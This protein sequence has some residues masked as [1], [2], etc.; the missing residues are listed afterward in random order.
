MLDDDDDDDD[1]I[2]IIFRIT[3]SMLQAFIDNKH[4]I[5]R[6]LKFSMH[7]CFEDHSSFLRCDA[8]SIGI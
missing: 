8:A 2:I 6:G 1:I 7:K 3:Q 4:E 5:I